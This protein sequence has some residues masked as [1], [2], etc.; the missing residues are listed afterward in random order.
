MTVVK[1]LG[2]PYLSTLRWKSVFTLEKEMEER[3][4]IGLEWS[5]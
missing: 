1:V 5:F 4:K 2:R 3:E